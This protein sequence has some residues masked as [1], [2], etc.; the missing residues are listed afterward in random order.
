MDDRRRR[1]LYRATHCGMKE[2]DVLIGRFAQARLAD[3]DD[4][5]V[6]RFEVLLEHSDNDLYNWITGKEAAPADA[7]SDILDMLIDF[8]AAK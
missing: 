8:Y 3:L 4:A 5:E 2:N 6:G 7:R 1:L